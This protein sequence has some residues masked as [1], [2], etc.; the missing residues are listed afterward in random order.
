M[1]S[2]KPTTIAAYVFAL[3]DA[4][5]ESGLDGTSI[6]APVLKDGLPKYDP[7]ER[8][9][10]EK[11]TE[12][13]NAAIAASGDEHFGLKVGEYIHRRTLHA[14]G[15]ALLASSSLREFAQRLTR[16]FHLISQAGVIT[17]R[18]H[19]DHVEIVITLTA[20]NVCVGTQDAFMASVVTMMRAVVSPHFVPLSVSFRRPSPGSRV[21]AYEQTF[22]CPIY[23]DEPDLLVSVS[24]ED[25]DKPLPSASDEIAFQNDQ[26]ILA[27]LAKLDK[28]DVVSR[29]KTIIMKQLATGVVTRDGV[30]KQLGMSPRTMQYKLSEQG[31]S[32]KEQLDEIRKTLAVQYLNSNSTSITEITYS[33]GFSDTSNFT[34]A[35]KRWFN[36]SPSEYRLHEK[37]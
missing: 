26:I 13:F 23:F 19:A 18:E 9:P 6:L 31:T 17:V 22:H 8:I 27:Y 34:R 30:S 12:L 10:A 4:L 1:T 29:V 14:L 3:I 37:P 25:F 20:S 28:N 21:D 36:R 32:F 16:Y 15:N 24:R 35:F 33:L 2:A 11:V 7:M 5:D